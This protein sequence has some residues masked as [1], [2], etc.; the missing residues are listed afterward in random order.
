[1]P[2]NITVTGHDVESLRCGIPICWGSLRLM[3]VLEG[4]S[5]A[6]PSWVDE[7][8]TIT[9]RQVRDL[10]AGHSVTLNDRLQLNPDSSM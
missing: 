10:L 3:V 8:L 6:I 4:H 5:V 9:G 7:K 1:M 2:T